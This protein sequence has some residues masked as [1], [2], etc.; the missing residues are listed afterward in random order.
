MAEQPVEELG[1]QELVEIVTAY[2]E[3]ALSTRERARADE[4]LADCEGCRAYLEQ[5]RTTIDLTGRVQLDGLS[6]SAVGALR[7]AFRRVRAGDA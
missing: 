3:D 4:H 6:D 7:E 2:L 5:M 1:C